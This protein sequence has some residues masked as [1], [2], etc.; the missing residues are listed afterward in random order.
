MIHDI[1]INENKPFNFY[2]GLFVIIKLEDKNYRKSL[3]RPLVP[4]QNM[5]ERAKIRVSHNNLLLRACENFFRV[6]NELS[7]SCLISA[8]MSAS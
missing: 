3:L 6:L 2:Q 8:L 4:L 1:A 7:G 5:P